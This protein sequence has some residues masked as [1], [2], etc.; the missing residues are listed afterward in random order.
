MRSL[1][2]SLILFIAGC[3][4]TATDSDQTVLRAACDPRAKCFN[5]RAVRDFEV[6]DRTALVVFVGSE[7]CPYL[8]TV[9]GFF[10]N[11]RTSAFISFQDLD[12]RICNLDRA[13]IVSGPF[14]R[15]DE[16]CRIS[17]VEPLNDDELVETFA[18]YG[19]LEPLPATGSGQLEVVETPGEQG[20]DPATEEFPGAPEPAPVTA[21]TPESD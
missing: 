12:G 11:L 21:A 15:D 2:G 13:Y 10:C 1:A 16:Y 8:I 19:I 14:S 9:D 3:A 18:S 7:R 17:R 20:S 5:Q 4:T 6:L